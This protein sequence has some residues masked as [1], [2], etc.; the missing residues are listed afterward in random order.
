[1]KTDKDVH[2]IRVS[3]QHSKKYINE[4][5]KLYR[6]F[7]YNGVVWNTVNC[8]YAYKFVDIVLNSSLNFKT[9]EK[10]VEITVDLSEYE[11]YKVINAV[12]LWNVKKIV[13]QDKS[14]PM[15]AG[16][17]I[18]YDHSISLVKAPGIQNGYMAGSDNTDFLYC[19]RLEQELII[20][21]PFSEQHHWNLVKIEHLENSRRKNFE[22]ELMSNKR[23]LGFIGR[24]SSLKSVIIRTK[25]EMARLMQS[26]DLSREMSFQNVE[27]KDN[28]EKEEE[29]T[30]YNSFLDDNIRVNA[31]KKIMLIK[32]KANDRENFLVQDKMSFLVS[33]MQILFPEY[34]CI[35]ALV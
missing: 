3:L 25:G 2:E 35:G 13:A 19:K 15:P 24:Y 29:T 18:N 26:Y 11:K 14:F 12:P 7:Q 5:E 33:E 23:N 20:V 16:D 27:I 10:I 8:P 30:D 9:G 21:S 22:Y 4:I 32:F 34:R 1:M 28:Y 17:R 31:Y 6:V